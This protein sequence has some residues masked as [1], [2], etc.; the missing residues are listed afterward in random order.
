MQ[1]AIH[2]HKAIVKSIVMQNVILLEPHRLAVDLPHSRPM[3]Q[4]RRRIQQIHLRAD[5]LV[6]SVGSKRPDEMLHRARNSQR[7]N[8]TAIC[9]AGSAGEE[10]L[11]GC[12]HCGEIERDVVRTNDVEEIPTLACHAAEERLNFTGWSRYRWKRDCPLGATR[13]I[14]PIF[15]GFCGPIQSAAVG[16]S[17]IHAAEVAGRHICLCEH[18]GG[19]AAATPTKAPRRRLTMVFLDSRCPVAW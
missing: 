8:W 16:A 3:V 1:I 14:G 5:R 9:G 10:P 19:R 4:L 2:L 15:V 12:F 11:V 6:C 7:R 17:L 18:L 13:R